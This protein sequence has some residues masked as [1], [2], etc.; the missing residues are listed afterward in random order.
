MN[1]DLRRRKR[2]HL[3]R[4]HQSEEGEDDD[5]PGRDNL[6]RLD[7]VLGRIDAFDRG[8]DGPERGHRGGEVHGDGKHECSYYYFSPWSA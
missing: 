7:L 8:D 2:T 1:K 3:E 4:Q 5:V 6:H